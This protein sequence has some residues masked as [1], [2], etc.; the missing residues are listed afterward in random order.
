M[1]TICA[2]WL[3]IAAGLGAGPAAAWWGDGHGILTK[4]A[5]LALPEELPAFFRQGG[6]MASHVVFDPDL[7][8]NRRTP[9]LSHAEHGEHYFD[10]EYLGGRAIPSQR[11]DFIALCFEMQLDPRRVGMAPYALAEWTERLAV[12]FAE[13]RQWPENEAIQQKCLVY[14]GILAHYAQDICQPLHTTRDFDGK[15][16][17][18]G[19]VL[20][21]GIHERVDSSVERL[22]FAPDSLAAEQ[23]VVV[24]DPLMKA[25]TDQITKSNWRVGDVYAL[26]GHWEDDSDARVRALAL[27]LARTSVRFTASLYATAWHQS[28]EVRLPRWLER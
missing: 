10:L 15:P 2:T 26:L 11:S 22:G 1:K 27:E 4:G 5:V 17:S 25:I 9:L 16:Q 8:K 23:E 7:F 19:T 28:A 3:A 18:D 13:H 24:F 12:A 14:A 20:G 6:D 21:K